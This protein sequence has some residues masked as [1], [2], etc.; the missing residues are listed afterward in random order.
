MKSTE[1][2]LTE[3]QIFKLIDLVQDKIFMLQDINKVEGLEPDEYLKELVNIEVNLFAYQTEQEWNQSLQD[4]VERLI[5]ESNYG[6][7]DVVLSE[8]ME[9]WIADQSGLLRNYDTVTEQYTESITEWLFRIYDFFEY[10][11]FEVE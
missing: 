8:D 11:I 2:K 10:N 4:T 1:L 7:N 3:S 6:A 9:E 5:E